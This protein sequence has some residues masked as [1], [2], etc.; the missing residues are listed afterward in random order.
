MDF[1]TADSLYMALSGESLD[2]LIKP[3]MRQEWQDI[4]H[5]WFPRTDT[6]ENEAY[7]KRTP[8]K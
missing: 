2:E 5:D 8:G 7:D 6:P 4:K 3:D 1:T